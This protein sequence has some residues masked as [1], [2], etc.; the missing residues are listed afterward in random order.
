MTRESAPQAP[1]VLRPILSHPSCQRF[2]DNSPFHD[3]A[4]IDLV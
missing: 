2:Q 3:R 4:E 1:P